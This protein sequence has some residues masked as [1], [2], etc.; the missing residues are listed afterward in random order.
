M[1]EALVTPEEQPAAEPKFDLGALIEKAKRPDVAPYVLMAAVL[2]GL[3]VYLFWPMFKIMPGLWMDQEGYYQHA[4]LIPL[5][6]CYVLWFN[7]SRY[8][9]NPVRPSW[10]ALPIVLGLLYITYSATKSGFFNSAVSLL[11]LA[12]VINSLWMLLGFRWAWNLLP[13]VIL[14]A[15][16]LPMWNR[17]IDDNTSRLQILSTEGAYH[18]L[19]TISKVFQADSLQPFRTELEPTTIHIDNFTLNIAA[20][21]SGMKLTLAMAAAALF[22]MLIARLKWWGNAVL[23]AVLLPLSVIINSLRIA[24]IGVVGNYRGHDA[25]MWFHDYGSYIF[26]ALAFYALYVIAKLLG[27]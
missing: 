10:F 13:V 17:I 9:K 20:A 19:N 1:D 24:I 21:C 23:I 26:I 22:I 8:T 18:I 3:L 5:A 2:S 7:W 4:P 27:W 14:A 16:S 15:M 11:F 25:G 12:I 6:V